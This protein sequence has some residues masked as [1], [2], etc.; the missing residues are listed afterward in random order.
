[1]NR[2]AFRFFA[3]AIFAIAIVAFTAST[4]CAQNDSAAPAQNPDQS[5]S[6]TPAPQTPAKKVWTNDDI[7]DLHAR[8]GASIP[9]SNAKPEVATGK[10][11]PTK[12]KDGTWYR[13]QILKL[14]AQIPPLE[15]KISQLQAALNGQTVTS[16]RQYGG[17]KPDD[18]RDELTRFQE[19]RDDIQTKITALE[20]QA[21][22]DGVPENQLP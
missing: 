5:A 1:M 8:S 16:T 7:S 21:R 2:R 3:A 10:P 11:K 19:Q 13:G 9:D 6:P 17:A 12:S 14:Q 20:D 15:E 18:W 4:S 22:H